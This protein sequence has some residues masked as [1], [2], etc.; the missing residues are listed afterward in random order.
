MTDKQPNTPKAPI[1]KPAKK[2][3]ITPEIAREAVKAVLAKD[4]SKGNN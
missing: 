2:G 4:K 1:L 3:K